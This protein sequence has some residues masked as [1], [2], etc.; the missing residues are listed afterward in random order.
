V[1]KQGIL[2]VPVVFLS[3]VG[4]LYA[5]VTNM[6]GGPDRVHWCE[7]F[8]LEEKADRWVSRGYMAGPF[9]P[10]GAPQKMDNGDF[11]MAGRMASRPGELPTIPAVAISRGD[12]LIEPWT[13]VRMLPTGRLPDGR[14]L[15]IPESTAIVDG[16]KI[17]AVVRREKANSLLFRSTDHGRSWS[18]PEEHN[19]PMAWSKVYAGM[20]ST[21]QRYLLCNVPCGAGRDLLVIAVSRPGEKTFCRM[22]KLRD[23]PCAALGCGPEWSYPSA[24]EHDGRLSVVYTSEKH[25]CVM[26]SIPVKSLVADDR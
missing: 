10:N 2:Y 12:K 20:L 22:W 23:G 11:L 6:Q 19:F 26:T 1:K 24:I 18:A 16:A 15:P 25:H 14:V 7:V 13:V 21:G 9:L 3:H 4:R 17:T 8:M 5:Y